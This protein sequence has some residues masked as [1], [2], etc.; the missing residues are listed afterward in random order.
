MLLDF[1]HFLRF[2][3]GRYWL[4]FSFDYWLI[5][6]LFISLR[7]RHSLLLSDAAGIS[8]LISA[9]PI[10]ASPDYFIFFIS[11]FRQLRWLINYFRC[12]RAFRRR[13]FCCSFRRFWCRH[14]AWFSYYAAPL[15]FSGWAAAFALCH[16][17]FDADMFYF[18]PPCSPMRRRWCQLLMFSIDDFAGVSMPFLIAFGRRWLL[19]RWYFVDAFDWFSFLRFSCRQRLSCSRASS[20]PDDYVGKPAPMPNISPISWFDFHF[21]C[22]PCLIIFFIFFFDADTDASFFSFLLMAD[23]FSSLPFFFYVWFDEGPGPFRLMIDFFSFAGFIFWLRRFDV[24]MSFISGIS[25][26]LSFLLRW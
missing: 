18:S 11:T 10:G 22:V 23:A 6:S 24:S 2:S 1:R 25:R 14:G 8:S 13:F 26:Y 17:C 7:C 19:F 5:F 4:I 16:A 3:S 15:L 9:M 21:I 12:R 20:M